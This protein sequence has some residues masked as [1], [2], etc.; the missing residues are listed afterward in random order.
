M[1][2]VQADRIQAALH[3]LRD[4]RWLVP[5]ALMPY[6]TTRGLLT[7][8]G[9]AAPP[10]M[11]LPPNPHGW[12]GS[13]QPLINAWARWDA[14]WYLS[15]VQDGYSYTPGLQSNVAFA[16]LLPV[17]MKLGGYLI[18]RSDPT[19]WLVAGLIVFN[20]ALLVGLAYL[21]RLI[22]LDFDRSI[23]QRTIFY[24]LIFPTSFFLSSVYAE[25]LFLALTVAAFYHAR[26]QQ[27]WV[28]GLLGA[29]A[30]L[31]RPHGILLVVPLG[32]EYLAQSRFQPRRPRPALLWLALLPAVF[33]GWIV[34]LSKRTGD[35]L[36]FLRAQTAWGRSLT[37]PWQTLENFFSGPVELG[38]QFHSPLDL[39]FTLVF[40]VLV[41]AAWWLVRPSYA[42]FAN[43]F[44][45][46]LV[47]A[48]ILMSLMRLGLVLFPAFIVLGVA[49]QRY[50]FIDRAYFVTALALAIVLMVLFAAGYRVA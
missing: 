39:G 2:T 30:T 4:A 41:V 19:G 17:L 21:Y 36:S 24:L 23:A 49:G 37:T 31:A 10:L 47:S 43:T 6:C 25:S 1:W 32:F 38:S 8:V 5:A 33:A 46:L 34:Y 26:R 7:V 35:P 42:L 20:L 11:Q 50:A 3:R 9:L 14:M 22:C 16:P 13:S 48:G 28:A 18:G 29:A 15:I 40:L 12:V 45:L 44:F 27:W